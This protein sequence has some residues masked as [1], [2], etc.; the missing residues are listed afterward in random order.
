MKKF[1]K[2]SG[3]ENLGFENYFNLNLKSGEYAI[4]NTLIYNHDDLT[5]KTTKT[6]L[7]MDFRFIPDNYLSNTKFSKTNSIKCTSE[8]I[9]SKRSR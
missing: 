4:L 9:L 7:S 5:N 3:E 1:F 8:R 2:N 6:R